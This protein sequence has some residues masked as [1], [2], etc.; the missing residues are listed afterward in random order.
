MVYMLPEL[1]NCNPLVFLFTI[2][3]SGGLVTCCHIWTG[4]DV[5]GHAG[6]WW[7]DSRCWTLP[8]HLICAR[9]ELSERGG[10]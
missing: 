6:G 2:S 5:A 10:S 8:W 3:F 4:F 1:K 9:V 7:I